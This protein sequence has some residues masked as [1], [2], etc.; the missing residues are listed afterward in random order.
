VIDSA[1]EQPTPRVWYQ[2]RLSRIEQLRRFRHEM[3]S[4]ED[5]HLSIDSHRLP[6]Q[7]EAVA[8]DVGPAVEDLRRLIIVRQDHRVALALQL[9]DRVDVLGEE[10]PF[11]GRD[12][13]AQA[14]IERGGSD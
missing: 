12:D 1:S 9:Q 6:C 10:R 2:H 11:E 4:A 8:H 7:R 13:M 5:D 3:H 14:L